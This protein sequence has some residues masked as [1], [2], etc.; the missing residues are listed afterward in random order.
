MKLNTFTY[1]HSGLLALT[2]L[3][4]SIAAMQILLK[5]VLIGF[6]ASLTHNINAPSP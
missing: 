1:V 2:Y 5:P 4:F 3:Y 6:L